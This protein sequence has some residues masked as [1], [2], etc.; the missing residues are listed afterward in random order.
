M[1]GLALLLS[2]LVT[3]LGDPS[4]FSAPASAKPLV[5]PALAR[6]T[7]AALGDIRRDFGVLVPTKLLPDFSGGEL[8]PT[9][10]SPLSRAMP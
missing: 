10:E 6:E 5:Q 4:K 3:L 2:V 9:G 1:R 8:A 7:S